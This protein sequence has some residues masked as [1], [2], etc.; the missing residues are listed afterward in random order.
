MNWTL[1][2]VEPRMNCE[3]S[4]DSLYRE[5]SWSRRDVPVGCFLFFVLVQSL[6]QHNLIDWT[7][8]RKALSA[9]LTLRN[10]FVCAG[11]VNQ[12]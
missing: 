3:F 6:Y 12:A 1:A 8:S 7:G 11:M 9:R 2:E 4:L 10:K 5:S